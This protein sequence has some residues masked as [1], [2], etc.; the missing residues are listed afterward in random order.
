MMP[1]PRCR[2]K[3]SG[4]QLTAQQIETLRQWVEQGANWTT[5]WAFEPP[6]KANLPAVKDAGW[7]RN[8]IDRFILA[9][10]EAEGLHPAPEAD[11]TTLIRRVYLDLTGLPPTPKDVDAF[12][13]DGSDKSYEKLVD[14]LLDSPR[15]GEH[16]ARFWLDAARYGDTHGL[17]LDNYREIWPYRDWVIKAFNAEQAL[18]PV[19]RRAA[20][21]RPSAQSHA[22]PGDRHGLQP[23]PCLDER[24]RVDRG[25]SLRPQHRGPD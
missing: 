25:G 22:R 17:H 1:T 6:R 7:P 16:M 13:A 4:K 12:L 3:K 24:G 20:C 8:P 11:P 23:L 2:P 15:Y 19:H 18:R 14:R 5:H 21:R 9:R 10:L